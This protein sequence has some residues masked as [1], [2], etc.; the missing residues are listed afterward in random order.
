MVSGAFDTGISAVRCPHLE[1][2]N[3]YLEREMQFS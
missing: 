1:A 2:R 3:G